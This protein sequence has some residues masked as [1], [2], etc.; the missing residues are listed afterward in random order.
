MR[1]LRERIRLTQRAKGDTKKE[2]ESTAQSIT[3]ALSADDAAEV[4]DKVKSTTQRVF[5]T[6]KDH[7]QRKSEKLLR[8]KQSSVSPTTFVDKTKWVINLSS[9]T[10]NEAEVSLLK[11]GL[12]FAV[13]PMSVPATEIIA[14]IESAVRPLDA[15]RADRRHR[16][17]Q[18]IHQHHP[19]TGTTTHAQHHE[20]TAGGS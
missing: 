8:E 12:N 7:Q 4:L 9:R 19:S 17:S 11:K 6:T 5:N 13:T 1:F 16:H 20:G 3:S 14:K 18:E 15:E 2:A 10:L